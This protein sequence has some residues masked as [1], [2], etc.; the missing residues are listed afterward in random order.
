MNSFK[1]GI[2]IALA[3]IFVPAVF[4]QTPPTPTPNPNATPRINARQM[5]QQKRIRQGIKSGE[6]TPAEAR[7]LEKREKKI[8]ADK[9][10]AKA[11]GIV[12]P[13]EKAKITREQ[14]RASRAIARKKHNARTR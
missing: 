4:A 12:T 7:H 9:K 3:L 5:H 1:R 14:N 10:A 11:D 6:L 8:Q 2:I 13:A